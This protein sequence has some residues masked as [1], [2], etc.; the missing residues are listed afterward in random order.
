ME[1]LF[2]ID[3][4]AEHLKISRRSVYSLISRGELKVFKVGSL[5]RIRESDLKYYIERGR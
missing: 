2:T 4:V 1:Q 5:T 3:E